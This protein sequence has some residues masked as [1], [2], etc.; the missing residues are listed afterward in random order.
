MR[1]QTPNSIFRLP[2]SSFD[3]SFSFSPSACQSPSTNNIC[4]SGKQ[5]LLLGLEGDSNAS[6]VRNYGNH[7]RHGGMCSF[8]CHVERKKTNT[9]HHHYWERI[10]R[11][12][13]LISYIQTS[14]CP[15]TNAG[16][17]KKRNRQWVLRFFFRILPM[18]SKEMSGVLSTYFCGPIL[19]ADPSHVQA[20]VAADKDF[21]CVWTSPRLDKHISGLGIPLPWNRRR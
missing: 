6:W 4:R 19:L 3:F 18:F 7:G 16:A 20:A 12:R 13:I 10:P 15:H 8:F 5:R 2:N 21:F 14:Q 1:R 11:L 9:Y 17:R